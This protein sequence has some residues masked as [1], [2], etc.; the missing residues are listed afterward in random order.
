MKYKYIV[1]TLGMFRMIH[2]VEAENQTEAFEIAKESDDNWQEHLGEMRI[3]ISEYTEE[4][5]AHFRKKQYFSD[6][7]SF[8]DEDGVL[9]YLH[10]NGAIVRSR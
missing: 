9:S 7:V 4:Q 6:H 5:I 8:K 3:D 1:E 2:V 10:P